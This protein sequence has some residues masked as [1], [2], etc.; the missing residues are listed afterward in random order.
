M[1]EREDLIFPEE[2]RRKL[3]DG[4][5]KNPLKKV[6]NNDVVNLKDYDG[7]K[8]ICSDG[9]WLLVRLSGTEPKL[10]IYSE[11][12]SKKKSLEYL[13]FGKKY[14]MRILKG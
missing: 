13:E 9:S 11:T 12:M 7:T 8:F 1:Y 5:K 14:A 4:L 6:L 3:V 10:R 2:K